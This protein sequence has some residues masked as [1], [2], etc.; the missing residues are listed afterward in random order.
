VTAAFFLYV[1][2]V[3]FGA[4]LFAGIVGVGAVLLIAPLLYFGLPIL[5]HQTMD[6]KTISDLTTFAVVIAAL[7]MIFIYRG[8]GLIRREIITPMAI[9]AFIFATA[10]VLLTHFATGNEIRIL[11]AISSL[12]GAGFLLLPYQ[13]ALDDASREVH[14]NPYF[15]ALTTAVVG[16][17]GGFAGAGG[18]FL[19]IPTLMGLFRLPTRLALGTAAF[20]GLIIA[21]VAFAGRIALEHLDWVLVAAIGIGSYLGAEL[22]TRYQQKVPTLILRRAVIGVVAI[23]AVRMLF[24]TG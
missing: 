2:V 23:S 14:P 21:V 4:S 18:G 15:L 7:R 1:V 13:A 11:F 24:R 6:F 5:F 20:S 16:F 19:L 10:G 22:G 12:V 9:P 3:G 8:F 17:V